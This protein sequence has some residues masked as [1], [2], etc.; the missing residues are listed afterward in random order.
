[1]KTT[2]KKLTALALA[3]VMMFAMSATVFAL[4][5]NIQYMT[6]AAGTEYTTITSNNSVD[7]EVYFSAKKFEE[8]EWRYYYAGFDSETQASSASWTVVSD[9][10][11]VINGGVSVSAGEVGELITSKGS[12]AVNTSNCG[13]AVVRAQY[14][15]YS[16]DLTICVENNTPAA[17]VSGISVEVLDAR[18]DESRHTDLYVYDSAMNVSAI[19]AVGSSHDLYNE[20][21]IAKSYPTALNA[22]NQAVGYSSMVVGGGY[23]SSIT[24]LDIVTEEN[25]TLSAYTTANWDY[26]GWNYCVIRGGEIVEECNMMSAG[27]MR[28][29]NNDAVYWAFGTQAQAAEYFATLV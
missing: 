4:D 21:G 27:I 6:P 15:T 25:V 16:L 23:V 22:L 19:N 20:T 3:I 28:L 12:V 14:G 7:L 11:D 5:S 9:P 2:M 17:N 1:M 26:Y 29:Q 24:A 18:F 10:D 8:G 13:V